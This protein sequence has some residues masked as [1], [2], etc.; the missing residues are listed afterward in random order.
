[1]LNPV[2]EPTKMLLS[3]D[4]PETTLALVGGKGTNLA[5]LAQAGF[6][7]PRAFLVTTAA[8][9][10]FVAAND[11]ETWLL[12][13]VCQTQTDD[14]TALEAVSE[15][16]R[17]RFAA[18]VLP[19]TLAQEVAAAYA[20]MGS[21]PVA[22]RSS[23]TAEDLPN[24]SFAGQQDT[25]L[26]VVG[27]AALLEAV[28]RCWSSLWTARAIGYRSR[29]Q[30]P[31][32]QVALAVVVQEM[33]QSEAAGVLFTVN[34]LS[35]KRTETVIEATLG[36]GEALVSGQV[37]PDQYVVET[38]SGR[39]LS[40]TLGA[41]AVAIH[42][43]AGGGVVT[44]TA[45]AAQ[46]Q[47]LP[48]AEIRELAT[49][50]RRVA[51]LYQAPQ[52][53]EWAWADGQLYLL[54][55][56]PITSLYPTPPGVEAEPLEVFFSLGAVQGMLDPIT[57]LGRDLLTIVGACG[58]GGAFGFNNT[59]ATQTVLYTAGERLWARV[60]PLLRNRIGRRLLHT[61]AGVADAGIGQALAQVEAGPDWSAA[62][63]PRRSSL[64]HVTLF[65]RRV[66][67]VMAFSLLRPERSRQ[68]FQRQL[69]RIVEQFAA[70]AA[71][72][73][74]L[75]ARLALIEQAL[76]PL[77]T[78][79]FPQ[80]VGRL[81]PGILMLNRMNVLAHLAWREDD[82]QRRRILEIARGLP[83]NVTTEMDLALWATAQQIRSDPVALAHVQQHDAAELALQTSA[84][85]LPSTAQ[86]ALD[87]FLHRYGMRGVAE[88]DLGRARWRED[89]TQ[90]MQTVQSY[91]QIDDPTQAPDA[92]FRRGETVAQQLI[93]DLQAGLRRQPRGVLMAYLA[94][95]VAQ[96]FR[97]LAGLRES[98]KFFIIQLLGIVRQGLL[99][100]GAELARQNVI[101]RPDDLFFLHLNELKGLAAGYAIDWKALVVERRTLYEREKLRRQLPRLLLS[102]GRAFYDGVRAT[103]PLREGVL[104]GTPVSPGVVEGTV[105]VVFD[106]HAA[107]LAPG[108]ILVCP[109]TD[110]AWTPLF[111]AAGGLVM[112]VGGLM[113]HGS[114]VAREYGIPAVVG[115][116]EATS[117]LQ[118]GQRIRVDG[119][120]GEIVLLDSNGASAA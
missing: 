22:V 65:L 110:P 107:Q 71:T 16:I 14:P 87:A 25:Y 106:P 79:L 52:D 33:V 35:G 54:Q 81:A 60:T 40:K 36:L 111:L 103:A 97:A 24:F 43:R 98:P 39:I 7:V 17:P 88:I 38:A 6:P 47:A 114:V 4:A 50:G 109:G 120:S 77:L 66:L 101:E 70:Q 11:L 74:T 100:S 29:N 27:E 10:C 80:A 118:S 2:I 53:I 93:A 61:F 57:P 82:V 32:D 78:F 86:A 84:G 8:Y 68:V 26:N 117:R 37:E 5:K 19:P 67:P 58:F 115:V 92:V 85:E 104:V 113:T 119:S 28:V 21:P 63:W 99:E 59:L 45:E 116:H 102:D 83:H 34:P 69:N 30:I 94:G 89:P 9:R 15:Q 44:T 49:L 105:R 73:T 76:V 46:R 112:E 48:D 1:M 90:V 91:L 75:S 51:D 108:E 72:A 3:L 31:H 64:G 13:Q 56:R 62:G 18:G 20:G 95:W 42:S 23:A 55:T 12:E 41:K 96:R